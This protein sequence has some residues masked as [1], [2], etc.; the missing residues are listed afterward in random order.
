VIE[1]KAAALKR[2]LGGGTVD[3]EFL[4]RALGEE[5]K[6]RRDIWSFLQSFI[7]AH[8]STSAEIVKALWRWRS[9]FYS[10]RYLENERD[11]LIVQE[12]VD[13][14]ILQTVA[15]NIEK[16]QSQKSGAKLAISALASQWENWV[17]EQNY[18]HDDHVGNEE[19]GDDQVEE[20]VRSIL[21]QRSLVVEWGKSKK[22]ESLVE[23]L[24]ES[25]GHG[26]ENTRTD[27]QQLVS[28][29][30]PTSSNAR[31]DKSEERWEMVSKEEVREQ[32][33]NQAFPDTCAVKT[34]PFRRAD[35]TLDPE[36]AKFTVK[37]GILS[38]G[39]VLPIYY[40]SLQEKL[41]NN[42][43][44]PIEMLPGGTIMQHIYTY[45]SA[46]RV[47]DWKVRRYYSNWR[48]EDLRDPDAEM[49]QAGWVVC[50][51]DIDPWDIV[52][53]VRAL[54]TRYGP[55]AVSNGNEHTD[56]AGLGAT[57]PLFCG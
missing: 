57:S 48:A 8:P 50:H 19:L 32:P 10:L 29:M 15:S 28:P 52:Q 35:G 37:S 45:K 24:R 14:N 39:Q 26:G 4:A 5:Y 27:E 51:D 33:C 6:H 34:L 55:G 23:I 11:K 7:D 16:F 38:W 30:R 9:A 42:A 25:Y 17:L 43:N 36:L 22:K 12:P 44:R 3:E 13:Q 56:K 2:C 46:A 40:G 41:T 49:F 54:G 31:S 20:K 18:G 21:R 1:T 47:G 53:R